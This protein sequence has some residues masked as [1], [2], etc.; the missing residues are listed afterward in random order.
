M[1]VT[2]DPQLSNVDDVMGMAVPG[3]VPPATSPLIGES[4]IRVSPLQNSAP[5]L[6][7]LST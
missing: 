4:A 3:H 7:T 2:P 6:N 5:L 1:S